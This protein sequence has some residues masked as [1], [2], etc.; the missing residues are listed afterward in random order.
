MKKKKEI[1][2]VFTGSMDLGGIESSLI[3][4]LD[5]I[6]YD[7]Y[8]VDLFLYAHHG[9][10]FKQIN[11]NVNVFPEINEMKYLECS[12]IKKIR[13][14]CFYSAFYRIMFSLVSL[15]RTVHI[16][17]YKAKIIK[18]F[19]PKLEKHYDIALG[20]FR[21]FDIIFEKSDSDIKV[22]WIHTDYSSVETDLNAL[23]KEF[24]KVD[25]I[26]A[27]SESCK[28]SF[29]SV[30][31]EFKDRVIVIENCLPKQIIEEKS[32]EPIENNSFSSE[33]INLLSVG[34]FCTAKNF[35]NVPEIAKSIKGKINNIKWY[36]IGFGPDEEL[37]RTK[38]RELNVEDTVVIL[39]KKNN[40]YPYIKNCDI[41]VQPSRYEGKSVSVIEAQILNKP[42]VITNYATSSSQLTDGFDGVI[43]PMDNEGCAKGI[44]DLINNEELRNKLIENTKKTDYTNSKE[45]EKLYSL[46][47]D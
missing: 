4:L 21:P 29:I 43:V 39:G 7:E 40:P 8:N 15:F 30:V 13:H 32:K 38:I 28:D 12:L 34:R 19:V 47:E 6:D 36:L 33:Y 22:G 20:F 27:V 45:I 17:E 44:V 42:V 10:L 3:G 37:I 18:K 5:S 23:I 9:L 35:D 26:A 31:P 1:L 14:G 25:I 46:M 11:E 16:D 2:V 41:Y 24:S